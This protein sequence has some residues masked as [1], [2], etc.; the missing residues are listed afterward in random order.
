[1]GSPSIPEPIAAFIVAVNTGD[2]KAFLGAFAAGGAV[3]DWGRA[4]TGRAA[5]KK[6]SDIE[7]LGAKG[8]FTPE[9]VTVDDQQITVVGDWRST[10]A[11]G[12]SSFRFDLAVNK[13][14]LMTIREG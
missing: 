8:T 11:N 12:R 5:I 2:E 3:D 13:I 9:R 4:F 10:H 1:M 7:F 14:T 6:W